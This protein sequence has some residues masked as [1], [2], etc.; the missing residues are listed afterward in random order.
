MSFLFG[1]L[2]FLS[3]SKNSRHFIEAQSSL[4][5]LQQ[6][7]VSH[8]PVTIIPHHAQILLAL[9]STLILSSY[10]SPEFPTRLLPLSFPIKSQ[11]I[12]PVPHTCYMPRPSHSSS[13]DQSNNIWWAVQV[14]K[15][16]VIQ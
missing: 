16:L 7:A 8:Y 3:Q 1:N 6:P 2:G 14:N 9:K 15:L 5:S 4:P 11:C 13:F 10:R 12:S